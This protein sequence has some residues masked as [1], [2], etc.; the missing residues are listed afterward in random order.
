MPV[1]RSSL[2]C[3]RLARRVRPK[4][5]SHAMS[6]KDEYFKMMESQIK[7]WDAEVDKLRAKSAQMSADARAK[8]DEQIK[9]MRANR[10]AAH[11]N[12]RKC[13]RLANRR[14]KACRPGWTRH[15]RL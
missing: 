2:H 8:Y 15:G 14:G 1:V 11:K 4:Q 10:D 13:A 9:V 5:R 12:Y 6:K 7:K 3:G